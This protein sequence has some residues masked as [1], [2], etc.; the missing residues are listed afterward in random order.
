[1]N[2]PETGEPGRRW[3]TVLVVDE[4][5]ELRT[6][7][8]TNLEI[9][10]FGVIGAGDEQ[11]ALDTL[12]VVLPDVVVIDVMMPNMDG[13]ALT[14]RIRDLPSASHVPII[15]LTALKE[16]NELV[17]GFEAGAD[18][19]L[20]KPF[21]PQELLARVRAKIRR[22]DSE[23]A[24]QPLTRLPGNIAIE[25]ELGKRL[26]ESAPW[27]VLY[28][29]MDNFKAFNDVYGF[30]HGDEAIVRLART[31]LEVTRRKGGAGDFVGHIGGDD[32]IVVTTPAH[33]T[34]IA[35]ETCIV[36]DR[37]VLGLYTEE[38]IQ[39]R[40]IQ[41]KDRR[42]KLHSYPIMSISVAVVTSDRR[43]LTSVAQIGEIAAELKAY[44]K[45]KPGSVVVKDLRK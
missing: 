28:I 8:A 21:G 33:A 3:R 37:E 2:G 4:D 41:T 43:S 34:P 38:D 17:R 13:Y 22:V 27:A 15:I 30:I 6:I 20:V 19:Y 40:G 5:P 16:T 25:R 11:T 1:M 14:R 7:L 23:A 9:A 12:E 18:D 39:R 44:A 10:G 42:G 29:D 26:N 45:A 32:F 31:L 24:L 36:F 35:E